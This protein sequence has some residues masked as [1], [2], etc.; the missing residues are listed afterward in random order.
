MAA[1]KAS[2][3]DDHRRPESR[4]AKKANHILCSLKHNFLGF[5]AVF[6]IYIRCHTALFMFFAPINS[7]VHHA[8]M[9]S[10]QNCNCA[11][12]FSLYNVKLRLA[13]RRES[14]NDYGWMGH[15]LIQ[16]KHDTPDFRSD[17]GIKSGNEFF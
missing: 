7:I 3:A 10:L 11:V 8:F 14:F 15:L 5:S 13:E 12:G 4:G 1:T 16:A 17:A 2:D 6:S 9:H